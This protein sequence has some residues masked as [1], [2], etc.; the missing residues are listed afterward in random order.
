MIDITIRNLLDM[1]VRTK[2]PKD[3]AAVEAYIQEL[4]DRIDDLNDEVVDANYCGCHCGGCE[5]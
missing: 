3:R 2:S 1:L 4:E 5:P